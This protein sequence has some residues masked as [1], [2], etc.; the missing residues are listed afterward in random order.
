LRRRDYDVVESR[1]VI[2]DVT[3]RRAVGTF[4]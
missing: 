1:E 3:K 4:L 2:D